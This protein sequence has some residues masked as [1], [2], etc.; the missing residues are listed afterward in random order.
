MSDEQINDTLA[1]VAAR[2]YSD[3]SE[4]FLAACSARDD[5]E[6]PSYV[7]TDVIGNLFVAKS[8]LDVAAHL[9]CGVDPLTGGG[10]AP[11]LRKLGEA[12]VRPGAR[13]YGSAEDLR[14]SSLGKARLPYYQPVDSLSRSEVA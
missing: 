9:L 5:I 14:R 4:L 6:R 3:V 1:D 10:G 7:F 11:T 12:E 8:A 13:I 2:A